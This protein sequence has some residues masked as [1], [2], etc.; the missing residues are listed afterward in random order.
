MLWSKYN[1]AIFEAWSSTE[2]NL[3]VMACPG[4]GKTTSL[5]HISELVKP[6][7]DSLY[8]AFNKSIVEEV[9]AKLPRHVQAMTLNSLGHRAVMAE[10]GR[11]QLDSNKVFTLI[12]KYAPKWRGEQDKGYNE[13]VNELKKVID[14][15]K[16]NSGSGD[17]LFDDL[18]TTFDIDQ[19]PDMYRDAVKILEISDSMTTVIDFNDQLRFPVIHDLSM[20]MYDNVLVD[21]AQDLNAIQA[22]LIA[23]LQGRYCFVGDKHQAIYGFRGAMANSMSVLGER[24]GAVKL[25][26]RLTYRCPKLVVAEASKLFDDIEALPDAPEGSVSEGNFKE[27]SYTDRDLIL[28]RNN[29]PLM[30]AAY[31]LLRQGQPCQVR[32]R[33]IGA[34]LIKLVD[35]LV[36]STVGQLHTLLYDWKAYELEKAQGKSNKVQSIH[37][38]AD[39]LMVF[40]QACKP[41]DNTTV[42]KERINAV[43]AATKGVL[44]ST[45][46][47]AKGLEA[48]NVYILQREL[49][50]SQYAT[51]DWEVVQERNIE[52]VAVTRARHS[53]V[54]VRA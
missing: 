53:L 11:V 3:V 32:G 47:R 48:Q 29:A 18:C 50:P 45:V 20:T 39:S 12:R 26:M 33:D 44:L 13:R 24:F 5:Q 52:Y 16:I 35:K 15:L 28:C 14:L 21:E 51:Q 54:Y 4:A 31:A 38:K 37:D 27:Q 36:C 25:P 46:H 1:E 30:A 6:Q 7:Q 49:M 19:Y 9:K 17:S 34:G 40:M 22:A 41:G 42:L 2:D 43:F 8:L 23:K 10:Y